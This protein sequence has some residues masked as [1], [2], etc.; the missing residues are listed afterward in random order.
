MIPSLPALAVI[1][2]FF[3]LDREI[4]RIHQSSRSWGAFEI[5]GLS[6]FICFAIYLLP[7]PYLY[8]K[9]QIKYNYQYAGLSY[10]VVLLIFG[11]GGYLLLWWFRKRGLRINSLPVAWLAC[12]WIVFNFNTSIKQIIGNYQ[13]S[14]NYGISE[15]RDVTHWLKKHDQ[16]GVPIFASEGFLWL[17]RGLDLAVY[18]ERSLATF[19]NKYKDKKESSWYYLILPRRYPR[20]TYG[21]WVESMMVQAIE[22]YRNKDFIIVRKTF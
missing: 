19:T 10:G 9:T 6:L 13:L 8:L 21:D 7:E 1:A 3:I 22:V 12:I 5:V 16:D 17:F 11:L 15:Y 14:Y 20:G 4:I 2:A 18:Q